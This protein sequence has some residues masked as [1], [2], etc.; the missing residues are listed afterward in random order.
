MLSSRFPKLVSQ[1]WVQ[2]Q[3]L[4]GRGDRFRLAGAN[5]KPGDAIAHNSPRATNRSGYNRTT[6]GGRLDQ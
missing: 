1:R 5:K 6:C 3:S 4:E 2:E